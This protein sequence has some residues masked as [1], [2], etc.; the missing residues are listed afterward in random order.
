MGLYLEFSRFRCPHCKQSIA[1]HKFQDFSTRFGKRE[2][3]D[4]PH[5]NTTLNWAKIPHHLAHYSMWAALLTFPIPFTGL[6]SF[7][8]GIWILG[9]CLLASATGMMLQRLAIEKPI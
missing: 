4:C 7:Q 1:V 8:T 5:C 3:F 6:Y 2:A 9:F